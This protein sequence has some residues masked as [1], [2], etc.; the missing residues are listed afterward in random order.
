MSP[1][2][3][4]A[5]EAEAEKAYDAE[6]SLGLVRAAVVLLNSVVYVAFLDHAGT[7]EPL[8]YAIVVAA[9]SYS[10]VVVAFRP[11]ERWPALTSS[12]VTTA[13]DSILIVL[14][15]AATGGVDSP[16]H[17]LWYLSL[18][19]IFFRYDAR[20]TFLAASAYSV[21]YVG[22]GFWTGELP[23]AAVTVALRV[24]YLFLL[25]AIGSFVADTAM[26][27]IREK[28]EMRTLME[29][30][31]IAEAK[32]RGLL[33]AAPDAIV[34]V[35]ADGRI[36]LVNSQ[37]ERAFGYGRDD[38]LGQPVEILLPSALAHAHARHRE[39]YQRA[40]EPR[41][42]GAGR[43]LTARRSDGTEFPVEISL[44]PLDVASG[45]L[46]MAVVRD[47]TARRQAERELS[48]LASFPELNP[49]AVLE[50][51]AAG[52]LTH[53]N[54]AARAR[55]A[56][57]HD[58]PR[59]HPLLHGLDEARRALAGGERSFQ[60][61]VD[62]G[63]R[64][65]LQSF[66]AAPGDVLR[67][68]IQDVTERR[69]AEEERRASVERL[70]ELERLKEL[71][72]LKTLFI[73]SAAHELK[74]PLTPIKLQI[75]ILRRA[76]REWTEDEKRSL[77]IL[78]RNVDRLSQLVTD[79]LDVTRLQASR[80]GVEKSSVDL[81]RL[82]L[83]AVESFQE[84]ARQSG[85]TLESRLTPD[86][87]VEADP[88]RLTQVLFNLLSNA[89]KFTPTGGRVTVSTS[90]DAT[91]ARVEVKDD[92][93]GIKPEDLKRLFQPFTQVHDTSRSTHAGTGLGLYISK[94]IMELHGG[95][96]TAASEGIGKGSIF[97]FTIPARSV[98]DAR[99][100]SVRPPPPPEKRP[101]DTIAK[102][103]REL[104]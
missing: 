26:S 30:A 52:Q 57:L 29:E 36:A 64:L 79:V 70:R 67:I 21:A 75:H 33:E 94:G 68:Y 25:A 2:Q 44:S 78:E 90:R 12:Y 24:G 31:R 40:P 9:L 85:V 66:N 62:V 42:M 8:A 15:L 56:T 88:K 103:A 97:G 72:R 59:D 91:Y 35:G 38:L 76:S 34:A 46:I 61:E 58:R 10:F 92:G 99:P 51:D 73:N 54:P 45:R 27:H 63:G 93:L 32:F 84:P 55:F 3:A 86:L 77:N 20:A 69:Q 28:L 101:E 49:D 48:R 16:F 81:N 82:V 95:T 100:T 5:R 65:F 83:E 1:R 18:A 74:T 60:R 50:V 11:H 37:A 47:V 96:M 102:R 13:S 7:N 104:I 43:E 71:D 4:L 41:P 14:W 53:L 17:L 80:L 23:A 6:R 19:A 22:L 98:A 39:E 87:I 89:I